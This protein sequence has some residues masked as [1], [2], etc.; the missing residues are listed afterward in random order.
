MEIV[1]LIILALALIGFRVYKLGDYFSPWFISVGIWFVIILAIQFTG[2]LL[3]P[4]KDQFLI[5]VSLWIPIICFSSMVTYYLL[6]SVKDENM[7]VASEMPLGMRFFTVIY[8]IS[9][10]ITPLYLYQILKIVLMFDPADMLYNLRILSIYNDQNYGILNYSYILNQ[11]LLVIALWKYPK[12]PMWQL[13]TIYIAILLSCFAI[14][15]KGGLFFAF[16]ATIFVLFEK[17]RIKLRTIII[18]AAVI[19]V[20]FFLITIARQFQS[21]DTTSDS[22]SILEFIGMYILSPAVAYGTVD[23]DVSQQFGSHTFETIYLFLKR[24]GFHVVVNVKLQEFVYVPI[25]TNVY[26]IFQ[27]FYQDFGQAGVSFFAFVYGLL[28][29]WAYRQFRNGTALGKCLYTYIAHV[30]ILQ[31]YQENIMLS[32]VIFIQ[33]IFFV[34]ILTQ[35]KIRISFIRRQQPIKTT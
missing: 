11:V 3:Y 32:L 29:G 19:I 13:I 33:F 4:L 24:F 18:W 16:I 14:M 17:G 6:P 1:I 30:L 2:D 34:V 21:D 10:I 20:L 15:E 35:Q 27:P 25:S 26:T 9:M 28:S 8:V 7:A 31:F 5:S 12:V 23:V 22:L